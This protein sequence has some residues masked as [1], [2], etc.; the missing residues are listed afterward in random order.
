[1][2]RMKNHEL[3]ELNRLYREKDAIFNAVAVRAGMTDTMFWVLYVICTYNEKMTQAEIT[4]RWYFPRQTINAC[5]KR[6]RTEG[7]VELE[8]I[9]GRRAD[10][11]VVLTEKGQTFCNKHIHPLL[12][13]ERKVFASLT[14]E[15]RTIF[16]ELFR[17][18]NNLYKELTG[19]IGC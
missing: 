12:E 6:L 9:P 16:I 7:F 18:Q 13:A 11:A 14:D 10:K 19:N 17:K 2:S 3:N 5:V 15:E 4:D 8:H 1:M